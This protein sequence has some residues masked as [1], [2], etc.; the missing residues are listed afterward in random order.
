MIQQ[1][2]AA[3]M[4]PGVCI[5]PGTPVGILE[6]LLPELDLILI[7]SV[8]PGFGGQKMIHSCLE[9]L[10]KL[11]KL[12]EDAGS[13]YLLSVDGGIN[14]DNARLAAEKGADV[15]VTGSAFFN[16]AD[17]KEAVRKLKGM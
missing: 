16:A 5:V 7:L 2:K 8:N 13:H 4:K 14:L 9:K 6:E 11:K 17:K 1:I 12:R 3:G 15:L 10:A